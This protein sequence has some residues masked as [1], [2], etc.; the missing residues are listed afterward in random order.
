MTSL[1]DRVY[2]ATQGYE[3]LP[4]TPE[5]PLLVV[6]PHIERHQ[7]RNSLF[8]GHQFH[9]LDQVQGHFLTVGTT[10][11]GKTLLTSTTMRTALMSLAPGKDCRAIIFDSKGDSLSILKRMQQRGELQVPI[12]GIAIN[13]SRCGAWDISRDAQRYDT[14]RDIAAALLPQRPQEKDSFWQDSA[15]GV[16]IYIL[17]SFIYR[18]GSRWTF[19][20]AYNAAFSTTDELVKIISWFPRGDD[21]INLL[22]NRED[23]PETA[24]GIMANL[25]TQ[26]EKLEGAAAHDQLA[27]RRISLEEFLQ[28][29]EVLV[30]GQDLTARQASIPY[31][32]AIFERLSELI[33][34]LPDSG[35]R[36][37]FLFL[38]E[39]RFLGLLP[40]LLELI[41][42]CRS[43]G[44]HC[45][46]AIQGIEG[47]QSLYGKEVADEI[48]ANCD[49]KLFLSL[50]SRTTA[51]WAAHAIGQTPMV[52]PHRSFSYGLSPVS[53]T[54]ADVQRRDRVFASD[55][56]DIPL[57]DPSRGLFAFARSNRV[58][59]NATGLF[60][61]P[62]VIN[63]LRP[64][65]AAGTPN[66][67]PW[68]TKDF[69]VKP[70]TTEEREAFFSDVRDDAESSFYRSTSSTVSRAIAGE[71]FDLVAEIVRQTIQDRFY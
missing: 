22:L 48:F 40:R 12:K 14:V 64:L 3:R 53:S 36:K 52:T 26:L 25:F 19:S 57:P 65:P 24:A 31:V 1:S 8:W 16:M 39:C 4:E 11:S 49:Y 30:I 55:L 13:D 59:P 37:I 56:L 41:T 21:V 47:M 58:N 45:F 18:R 2:W 32:S 28:N 54:Q 6:E 50:G 46:L 44:L 29:D 61:P 33:V 35:T 51:E 66:Q 17:K 10:G 42:F 70:W 34:S 68:P 5:S 38:D 62:E 67:V 69:Y 20:D 43:K 60:Y 23:A 7:I 63:H 71:V 27:R 15:R 9:T